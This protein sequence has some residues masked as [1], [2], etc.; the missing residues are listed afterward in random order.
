MAEWGIAP[1]YIVKNWTDEL[2]ELMIVKLV[3]RKDRETE[4]M[5]KA[6]G[7]QVTSDGSGLKQM[8][9]MV[10]VIDNRGN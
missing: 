2:F 9:S 1:D 6:S 7:K 8:G 3:E 10:K 5:N 4:S